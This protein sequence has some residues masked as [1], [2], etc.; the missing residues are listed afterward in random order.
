[1][2]SLVRKA[3]VQHPARIDLRH[4][5]P[6][7]SSAVHVQRLPLILDAFL[8]GYNAMITTSSLGEVR[9]TL[10]RYDR[11]L[12]GFAFEGA[13]MGF[14]ACCLLGEASPE[15]FEGTIRE[16]GTEHLYQY[17]VG[18][19]W[20]L[21]FTGNLAGHPW[22]DHLDYRYRMIVYDGIGFRTG[23]FRPPGEA[24]ALRR[25]DGLS[26]AARRVAYQ[27]YGRAMWFCLHGALP[28]L[29]RWADRTPD[30][31]R[32]DFISGVGLAAAYSRI[33][34]PDLAPALVRMWP[35]ADRPAFW[36]GI[37]FGWEA[38]RRQDPDWFA[39]CI[40]GS[41]AARELAPLLLEA[42]H[43]VASEAGERWGGDYYHRWT[44][45]VRGRAAAVLGGS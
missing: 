26:P 41:T 5:A 15:G 40:Q 45:G 29:L 2:R 32:G 44:D 23:F 24:G 27:G 39:A 14:G 9:K 35:A 25:M 37:A 21:D 22:L 28:A 17:Y 1:V 33:D 13:G 34:D 19:G 43:E 7:R 12:R 20:W 4:L 42:V 31:C 10:A 8:A 18:L 6:E 3:L 11:Y 36:Q 16:L 38:R 30:D